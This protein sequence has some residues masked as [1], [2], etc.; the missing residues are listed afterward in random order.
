MGFVFGGSGKFLEFRVGANETV[1]LGAHVRG[2]G[3]YRIYAF[4]P[5]PS[6]LSCPRL[7]RADHYLPRN[8][9]SVPE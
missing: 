8:F 5:A 9:V 3:V 4:S 6:Q 7:H 2:F 1:K